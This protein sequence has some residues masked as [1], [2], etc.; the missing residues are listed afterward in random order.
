VLT[1]VR[2]ERLV[3]PP[4]P[5][6]RTMSS[7]PLNEFTLALVAIALAIGLV[8]MDPNND[9]VRARWATGHAKGAGL[10]SPPAGPPA[11]V[12]EKLYTFGEDDPNEEWRKA[13]R[14]KKYR[15]RREMERESLAREELANRMMAEDASKMT[16]TRKIL[17]RATEP[18]S[19]GQAS[20][21]KTQ[22]PTPTPTKRT[23]PQ[24]RTARMTPKAYQRAEEGV[25]GVWIGSTGENEK[26]T[27][28]GS[29]GRVEKPSAD[30][31]RGGTSVGEK[32]TERRPSMIQVGEKEYYIDSEG[33]PADPDA[34]RKAIAAD[35]EAM[36]SIRS[37]NPAWAKV[38][39][40]YQ[41]G[42]YNR[43][44]FIKVIQGAYF[45]QWE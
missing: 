2:G 28:E 34:L 36:R 40:G 19:V 10:S 26:E 11:P 16:A 30:K 43:V 6:R 44:G 14:K 24:K 5:A 31:K 39:D 3:H 42:G 41:D 17:S 1:I 37:H 25:E 9:D 32:R 8:W 18:P 33:V 20:T 27:S 29:D 45:G 15:R 22:P 4:M 35:A 7:S 23:P 38:I 12:W 13:E 21:P